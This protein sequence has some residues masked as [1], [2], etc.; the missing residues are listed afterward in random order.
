MATVALSPTILP[1]ISS[2]VPSNSLTPW[3][4][5]ARPTTSTRDITCSSHLTTPK[6][7]SSIR[8]NSQ[9]WEAKVKA[10][11]NRKLPML[12]NEEAATLLE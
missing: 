9:I 12:I 7:A 2:C 4:D 10:I 1:K 5:K 8:A 6:G 11:A 3:E